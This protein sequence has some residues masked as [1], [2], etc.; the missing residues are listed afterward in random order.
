VAGVCF[1][2]Y[3]GVEQV[4]RKYHKQIKTNRDGDYQLLVKI[5]K[6]AFWSMLGDEANFTVALERLHQ[7]ATIS[8]D[9]FY[10]VEEPNAICE[11]ISR[12]IVAKHAPDAVWEE[13]QKINDELNGYPFLCD[14]T[15]AELVY[16]K[17]LSLWTDSN[18]AERVFF[19]QEANVCIFSARNAL[20]VPEDVQDYFWDTI[21]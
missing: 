2:F 8:R 1:R 6:G 20:E 5:K 21:E 10:I 7:V 17:C 19:C 3:L 4:I 11:S 14:D 18:L 15:Y 12:L 16:R 13:A 9:T